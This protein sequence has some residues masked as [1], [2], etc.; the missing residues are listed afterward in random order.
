MM[1]THLSINSTSSSSVFGGVKNDKNHITK[2]QKHAA[3]Y[4]RISLF[5]LFIST[6][7]FSATKIQKSE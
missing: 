4:L 2:K 1:C 7:L 3:G 5:S 6:F